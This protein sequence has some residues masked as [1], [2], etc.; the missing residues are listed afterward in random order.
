M[1]TGGKVVGWRL[2]VYWPASATFC[3]G[4]VVGYDNISGR[5][6]LLYDSRE[7]EHVALDSVKVRGVACSGARLFW[8]GCMV[9][10][11]ARV[12]CAEC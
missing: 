2:G 1:P 3:E 7:Q 9:E 6:Q 4:E 11:D 5:H 8:H 10:W 12:A